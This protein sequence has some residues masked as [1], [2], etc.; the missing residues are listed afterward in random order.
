V[1]DL[2]ETPAVPPFDPKGD[3]RLG[4]F[5][6]GGLLTFLGWGMGIV[7]NVLLHVLSPKGGRHLFG[8]YFGQTLGVYAW[9]T[10]A[11]G[12]ATGAMG[13]VLIALARE[14]PKGALALPGSDY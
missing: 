1:V 9:A 3:E 10:L 7:V 12:V 6:A 14:S 2:Q 8:L 5:I 13:I 11:L 4:Y